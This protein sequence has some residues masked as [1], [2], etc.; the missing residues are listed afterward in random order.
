MLALH[1]ASDPTQRFALAVPAA[2]KR[3]IGRLLLSVTPVAC[4]PSH[5]TGHLLT[6]C[7]GPSVRYARNAFLVLK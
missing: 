4:L 2:L 6:A 7:N 3:T 1:E 5:L